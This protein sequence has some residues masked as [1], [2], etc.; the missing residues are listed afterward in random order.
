MSRCFP[1]DSYARVQRATILADN[2][3]RAKDARAILQEA[4][5]EGI[6]DDAVKSLLSKIDRRV[7]VV[8]LGVV[9]FL[10]PF[11]QLALLRLQS[12]LG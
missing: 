10:V 5:M 12:M 1:Y 6:A 2:M 4:V 7:R 9:A 11:G 8:S 3:G